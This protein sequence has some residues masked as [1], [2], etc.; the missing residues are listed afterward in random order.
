MSV[1][2]KAK[3]FYL[4]DED[5]AWVEST[6]ASLSETEKIQQ[7]FCTSSMGNLDDQLADFK[8]L[9]FKPGGTLFRKSSAKE[10]RE[11]VEKIQNYSKVPMLIAAD[12]DRG[13]WNLIEEG[14]CNGHHMQIAA[15]GDP[16]LSYKAGLL[17]AR[18]CTATGVNW[19]FGPVTDIDYNPY[20]PIVNVRSFGDQPEMV[21]EF[22]SRYCQ[23]LKDGGML[24]CAKHWPGDGRDLRDQHFVASVNDLSVEEWDAT[25]GM[26]YGRLIDEGCPTVMTAHIMQ[27]AYSR[28]YNP[29]IK[30]EEI[31]V[32]SLNYDLHNKLLRGKLGFNGLIVTDAS[33]MVGFIERVPRSKAVPLSIA[34]GADMFLFNRDLEED[35]EFMLKGYE[36]GV[37]TPERLDEAVTRILAAK[38]MLKLHEKAKAGALVPPVEALE[39]FN[40]P[41]GK[42]QG[43]EISDK[44]IT[45]VRNDE[46][47]L[48]FDCEKVKNIY[49]IVIGDQPGYHNHACG[50]GKIFV[51]ELEK[52]GFNVILYDP[53]NPDV[54]FN[55]GRAKIADVKKQVD[56]ICYFANVQTSGGDSAARISWPGVRGTLPT[57]IMDIPT[58]M[59]SIDN[60][61]LATDAPGF[62]TMV[63]AYT[64]EDN[65]V[66]MLVGKLCGETTFKGVSPIDPFK[67]K[68][69]KVN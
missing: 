20:S 18:E 68:F 47:V 11:K 28:Y 62:K 42:A 56:V 37:I 64:S 41:A 25:Y 59:V 35:Y 36:D 7:L 16:E 24:A 58:I 39:I 9:G 50:Y 53:E 55:I 34:N 54:P 67:G 40:D 8:R 60:P 57:L 1:N 22:T 48:P 30:D 3:P 33:S 5:I 15:T 19:D 17:C 45:L 6:L 51:E 69:T 21:A 29:D 46:N 32:G 4:S 26:I 65:N 61:Y 23:G 66:K 43:R 10:L 14:T 12:L 2:L 31:M 13:A 27:P 49:V 44:G 52:R 38:A 63:N